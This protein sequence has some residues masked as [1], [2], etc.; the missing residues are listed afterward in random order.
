M[1][2]TSTSVPRTLR[3]GILGFGTVGTGAFRMLRDNRDAIGRKTGMSIEVV[4]IGV[5]DL[6]KPR[7][8]PS[9]MFTTDLESIVDDP[10]ID[11]ILEL[12]DGVDP[13]KAMVERALRN[14]KSVVTA[15]KELIAKHGSRLITLARDLGLDLHFEAAVGGGIPL[16]Q[17][18]KHQ[19]AG[20]DV[21]RLMGILNGTTNY[22]LTQM[23]ENGAEFGD[24]LADAQA[25]GYAE[26][27]PTN[28]VDGFD[29]AYKIAILGS[30]A[31]G[32]Q[33]P[34]DGVYREGIRNVSSVDMQYAD[35]LGFKIKLLGIVHAFD[36]NRI[37]A[38]VH[39][40]LIRKTH[41]LAHVDDVYNAVW[42]NG[43]FVG[44]VMF[45]GRGAGSD[46]TASA[47]IGDLIDVAR[48]VSIGG[49]GSAIPYDEGMQTV[50]IDELVTPY[51]LRLKVLD[52]PMVLGIIATVF[53]KFD[54]SL[55]AMEMKTLDSQFGEIAFLTHPCKEASFREAIKDLEASGVVAEVCAWIR[56]EDEVGR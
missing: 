4:R 45:S 24:A 14:G 23:R 7:T 21:I 32:K 33:V 47:V 38:R 48:N 34:M 22:I 5:S 41:P 51:Y 27:D 1:G 36:E 39:P 12:I 42:F 9:D 2:V 46:P 19:L 10:N 49:V 18:L 29:A 28:D 56:V 55:S 3:V 15:N 6:D 40:T 13:A 30:I 16:V 50:S 11:V 25:K 44:D 37:L 43:D 52:K 26:A 31:F 17:P 35:I 53:G 8:L 20:N 54:V